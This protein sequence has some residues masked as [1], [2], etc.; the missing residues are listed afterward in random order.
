MQVFTVLRLQGESHSVGALSAL[1][2]NILLSAK[3]FPFCCRNC[4]F[5]ICKTPPQKTLSN[6]AQD[7]VMPATRFFFRGS[8]FNELLARMTLAS[9]LSLS[10]FFSFLVD[11]IESF[12]DITARSLH[13]DSLQASNARSRCLPGL[14]AASMGAGRIVP[15][16]NASESLAKQKAP[17]WCVE[18]Y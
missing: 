9:S 15:S 6:P 3:L 8:I 5:N 16:E 17:W 13:L 2:C 10:I 18:F 14:W 1:R 4:N 11:F 7:C 12:G